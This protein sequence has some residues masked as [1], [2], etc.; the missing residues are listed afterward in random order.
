MKTS[1]FSCLSI[2]WYR[3][4]Y[5]FLMISLVCFC[6]KADAQNRDETAI[7]KILE[8]QTIAWNNDS[9]EEFMNGYWQSDSLMF[10]GK[11]GMKYGYNATLENYKKSYPDTAARGKL[12]FDILHVKRLSKQYYFVTGKWNLIRSV[13]NLE[14]YFT[15]LFQKIKNN[16]VIIADHST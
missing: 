8:D 12:Y 5:F 2:L 9:I 16:W 15:L 11:N 14:G 6:K 4:L 10:I 3:L 7:R 13:G 1:P